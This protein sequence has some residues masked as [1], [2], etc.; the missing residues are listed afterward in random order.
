MFFSIAGKA[1][2]INKKKSIGQAIPSY[3]MSILKFPKKLCDEITK[4]FARFW[5]GSKDNKKKASI[6]LD[7]KNYA[8]LKG[9]G[10]KFSGCG[11]F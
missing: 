7:G 8:F 4:K 3:V 2:L 11:R 9:W 5:W 1:I 10:I 6:G